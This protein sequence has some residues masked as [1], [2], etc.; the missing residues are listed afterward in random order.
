MFPTGDHLASR[1]KL[2]PRTVQS[3][4]KNTHGPTG[5]GNRRLKGALTQAAT[6]TGRTSTLPGARYRRLIKHVPKKKAQVAVAR[7]ILT[8]A[9]VLICDP[10]ARYTDLGADWHT[11]RQD[12]ARATREHIRAPERLGHTVTLAEAA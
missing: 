2:T 6:T 4:A 7:N 3:G 12:P 9:R 5:K 1:A 10:D 11:R 8:I